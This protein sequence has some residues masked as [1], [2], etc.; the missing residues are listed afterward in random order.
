[1]EGF[2][3]WCRSADEIEEILNYLRGNKCKD[4]FGNDFKIISRNL[5]YK[6]D[7]GFRI[8]RKSTG[9]VFFGYDTIGLY[10]KEEI[11]IISYNDFYNSYIN[12]DAVD[13]EKSNYYVEYVLE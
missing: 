5:A 9:W 10:T 1:M 12:A 11:G 7:V 3:V 6:E 2:V 4:V 8:S 13:F